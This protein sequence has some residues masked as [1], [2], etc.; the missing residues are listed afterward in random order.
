ME[1]P[2]FGYGE[3]RSVPKG[4]T[5]G[6]CALGVGQ[7]RACPGSRM[8]PRSHPLIVRSILIVW[9]RVSPS[10]ATLKFTRQN[11]SC[12]R[13]ATLLRHVNRIT[14]T[15]SDSD[16]VSP[17]SV[18]TQSR[19]P[20]APPLISFDLPASRLDASPQQRRLQ[21]NA[22]QPD[23]TRHTHEPHKKTRANILG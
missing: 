18:T 1:L 9:Y 4:Q 8:K 2:F 11:L 12:H 10:S 15:S 23:P 21:S 20:P 7:T 13:V 19:R 14:I 3:A 22:P 17:F 16:A 5:S 6:T